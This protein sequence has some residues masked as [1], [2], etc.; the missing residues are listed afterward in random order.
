MPETT[1]AAETDRRLQTAL[2]FLEK[3]DVPAAERLLAEL[4]AREPA[5][6]Q[7][8]Q[9]LGLALRLQ[10]RLSEALELYRR[11]LAIDPAQPHVHR[12]LGSLLTALGS[13]GEAVAALEEAV[14]LKPNFAEAHL[15]LALAQSAQG[16]HQ[17]AERSCRAALRI[18]PN[19]LLAK[20]T[21]ADML[22]LLGRPKEA[23]RILRQALALGVRN[24]R[25]ASAL[26]HNLAI[27]LKQQ[28]RFHEALGFFDAALAKSPDLVSA[29]FNRGNVFQQLGRTE[30]AIESYRRV[31]ARNPD[32]LGA[33]ACLAL[34]SAQTGDFRQARLSAE[35]AL[36]QDPRHPIARIA[37]AIAHIEDG[38]VDMAARDLT[39]L[40]AESQ[41][42][43]DMQASFAL[44]FAA[45]A[46]D[47]H[48]ETFAAFDFYR[49]SNEA[50]RALLA[51]AFESGRAT[52]D[53]RRFTAYFAKSQA[54]TPSPIP[55]PLPGEPAAHL[56]ILGFMRSGTT[57]LEKI[58]ATHPLVVDI[59][60]IEFLTEPARAFLLDEAGLERLSHLDEN[61]AARWRGAY[62]RSVRD[63]GLEVAGKVFVDKM[64][65]N[66]LRLPLIA[67]LFPG[68]K[69]IFA[70]RDPRDVVF[71]CFRRRF[72][73]TPF[74]YEFFRLGDCAA[75]YASLMELVETGRKKLPL[76]LKEHRYEDMIADFDCSI[77]AACDF[78]GIPWT[79][80]MRDFRHAADT[81]DR[82]SAS[83]T[84]VRRGLYGEAVG[85]WR[86]YETRLSPVLP[87]L[88]PWVRRFGYPAG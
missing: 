18:Q 35:Q 5:N 76:D 79:E 11:S 73:P 16:D 42:A 80:S 25:Q 17:A 54:W 13:N 72:S 24:P 46:F 61:E 39:A 44:G 33:L 88:E 7:A 78:A 1:N 3:N 86:R 9:L 60:E 55:H 32:H 84:Q 65:F 69:V 82:R 36:R 74:S 45:D 52:R 2:A 75:F 77:R 68:A 49:A 38:D 37:L 12:N 23:E 14:R 57:L 27:A 47:R 59:D 26:E 8:L 85:L 6:A 70:I 58:L 56:F 21:L 50:R 71:S 28:E 87:V 63:A 66:S 34:L 62:W 81:V 20:Q 15:D 41:F 29:E 40:V 67:R 43:A 19:F 51:P 30:D 48:G 83:A 10:G 53:A 31:L 4:V 22:C 64:P